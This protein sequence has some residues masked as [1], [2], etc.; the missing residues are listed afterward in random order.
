MTF[1]LIL[2]NARIAGTAPDTPLMDIGIQ[3]GTIAAIEADL[4]GAARCVMWPENCC[5]PA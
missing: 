1:D 4:T 5:P 3:G 2:R